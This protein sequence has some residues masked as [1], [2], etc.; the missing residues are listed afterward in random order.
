MSENFLKSYSLKKI[1][2]PMILLSAVALGWYFQWEIGNIVFFVL[3]LI[4]VMHPI[5]SR[6]TASGTIAMLLA[7]VALLVSQKKDLAETTSIWTYY[8]MIFTAIM[9]LGEMSK[10][11]K[12]KDEEEEF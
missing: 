3:F 1:M 11:E 12:E 8:L 9:V 5:S 2:E 4:L 10:G 7:T 6:F